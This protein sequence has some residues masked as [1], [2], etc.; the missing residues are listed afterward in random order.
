MF[1]LRPSMLDQLGLIPA[2]RWLAQSRLETRGLRVSTD[3]QSNTT[4]SN[5]K[6]DIPR[7]APDIE[8][9]LFRV[10]QEAI[11]NIARHA[12]ARNVNI[13]LELDENTAIV[14]VRDDGIGFDLSELRVESLRE[15]ESN[16]SLLSSNTRGLG[17]IGMQERIELLGGE[18]MITTAPGS[19]T[20]IQICVPLRE[21]SLVHD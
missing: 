19:G 6:T 16:E 17:I 1:D 9:A 7:L 2:V 11:N 14:S 13:R 21:R 3:V 20:H 8:T 5:G 15:T 10:V 18:L 12:A 4:P